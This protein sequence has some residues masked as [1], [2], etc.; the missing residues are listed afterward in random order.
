MTGQVKDKTK[1][2]RESWRA[3]GY[4]LI[5]EGHKL[6]VSSTGLRHAAWI[7]GIVVVAVQLYS[8]FKPSF[9]KSTENFFAPPE[10]R[11]DLPTYVPPIM[12]AKRDAQLSKKERLALIKSRPLPLVERIKPINLIGFKGIPPGSEVTA[13]LVSGG[14]NGMVKAQMTETLKGGGEDLLPKGTILIGKGSSSDDRL[15]IA[16]RKA[17]RPDGESTKIAALAYD[18]KDRVVGLKGKKISD[19]AFKLAASA[20]LIFLGGVADGMRD[21]NSQNPFY[22]KRPTMR[23]AALNGVSSATSDLSKQTLESI[24][25]QERVVVEHSTKLIV[26]FGDSDGE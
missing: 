21:D 9:R 16:F 6:R 26:I 23:D 2:T 19:Y 4:G 5:E 8:A 1:L 13:Q 25:Q 14:A 15:Y 17:V 22:Q 24:N 7:V 10:V 20:G 11:S 18:V 3:K 12:D